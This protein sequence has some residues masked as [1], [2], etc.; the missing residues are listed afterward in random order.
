M[1]PISDEPLFPAE[2][3][4]PYDYGV[5]KRLVSDYTLY[6][7]LGEDSGVPRSVRA[8]NFAETIA[9]LDASLQD[10][11]WHL[12][13]RDSECPTP[14]SISD[15]LGFVSSFFDD[16]GSHCGRQ[17]SFYV[18]RQDSGT[19]YFELTLKHSASVRSTPHVAFAVPHWVRFERSLSR[20][21]IDHLAQIRRN[22]SPIALAEDAFIIA[23]FVP[24]STPY[25]R[26]LSNFADDE[27]DRKELDSWQERYCDSKWNW[28]MNH[29]LFIQVAERLHT[30]VGNLVADGPLSQEFA[31][32]NR[33]FEA[34]FVEEK[35]SDQLPLRFDDKN[36]S[37]S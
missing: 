36:G 7:C 30:G 25:K 35:I 22:I 4:P 23:N 26:V 18:Q 16:P 21:I 3:L 13:R 29:R 32:A 20:E 2:T 9:F 10:S 19:S 24:C 37:T 33:L 17:Y 27:L 34:W 8:A 12:A 31:T 6:F 14:L 28:P 5:E 15:A 1:L 11:S